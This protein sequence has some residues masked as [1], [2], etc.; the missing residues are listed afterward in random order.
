MEKPQAMALAQFIMLSL[1]DTVSGSVVRGSPDAA[2]LTFG[3]TLKEKSTQ[4]DLSLRA[5]LLKRFQII[6]SQHHVRLMEVLQRTD[7]TDPAVKTDVE[8][9]LQVSREYQ[10]RQPAR[11]LWE[12]SHCPSDDAQQLQWVRENLQLFGE[13]L[14]IWPELWNYCRNQSEFAQVNLSVNSVAAGQ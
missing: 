14:Q 7:L 12:D 13:S 3:A 11:P 1:Q 2:L 5:N 10:Q 6:T 4:S 8:R 9:A